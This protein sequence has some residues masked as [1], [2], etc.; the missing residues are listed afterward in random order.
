ME[1]ENRQK[2]EG[3][4]FSKIFFFFFSCNILFSFFLK[5]I[6]DFLLNGIALK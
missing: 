5:K 1:M 6:L 2:N 4:E 3:K